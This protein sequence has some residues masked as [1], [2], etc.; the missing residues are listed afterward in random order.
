MQQGRFTHS[1][2]LTVLR[3]HRARVTGS[4]GGGG[5]GA[6]VIDCEYYHENNINLKESDTFSVTVNT[7]GELEG[8][9]NTILRPAYKYFFYSVDC[10]QR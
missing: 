1:H 6:D 5:N 7:R 9:N 4:S 3:S 10:S 8:W 2:I